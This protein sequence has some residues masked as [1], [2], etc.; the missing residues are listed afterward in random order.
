MDGILRKEENKGATLHL[1]MQCAH[2]HG[3]SGN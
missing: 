3:Q 1:R 2:F